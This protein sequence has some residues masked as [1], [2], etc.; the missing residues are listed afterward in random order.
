LKLANRFEHRFSDIQKSYPDSCDP[1][2]K[3]GSQVP[4]IFLIFVKE[5]HQI[6]FGKDLL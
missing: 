3:S 4:E 1:I 5:D 6:S 2:R